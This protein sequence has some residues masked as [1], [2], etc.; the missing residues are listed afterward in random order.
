[1]TLTTHCGASARPTVDAQSFVDAAIGACRWTPSTPFAVTP[2]GD[3]RWRLLAAT[4]IGSGAHVALAQSLADGTT[5]VATASAL[6]DANAPTR[7][8]LQEHAM[9]GRTAIASVTA[10]A[11]GDTRWTLFDVEGQP[12]TLLRQSVD[13]PSVMQPIDLSAVGMGFTLSGCRSVGQTSGGVSFLSEQV[14]AVW[15]TEVITADSDGRSPTR[16]EL[17]MEA[18]SPSTAATRTMLS[19][20]SFVVQTVSV[21]RGRTAIRVQRFD[22][23]LASRGEGQEIATVAI[24][25]KFVTTVEHT[26]GLLALWD[27]AVDTLPPVFGLA[28]RALDANGRPLED[29]VEH[30]ELGMLSGTADATSFAGG[31]LATGRFLDGTP[32]QRFVVLDQRGRSVGAPIDLAGITLGVGAATSKIVATREGALVLT[33]VSVGTSGGQ[34]IAIP[35]RC[36]P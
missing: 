16:A 17:P 8:R 3:L 9:G 13:R 31:I 4:S 14:R 1:M 6:F 28:T 23:R 5:R 18:S 2:D 35:I 25:P 12:C 21:W 36:A 29:V 27:N 24:E 33:E 19:D 7:V 34:V 10:T 32:R 22:E 30:A 11:S 20:R 26:S 15:G